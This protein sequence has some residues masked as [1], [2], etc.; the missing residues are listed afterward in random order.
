[1]HN[2]YL[3]FDYSKFEQATFNVVVFNVEINE[4]ECWML[5][6]TCALIN[7]GTSAT[8]SEEILVGRKF[9][10]FVSSKI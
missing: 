2:N 10:R 4:H 6:V 8:L 7:N 5:F 3:K 9:G 1:M